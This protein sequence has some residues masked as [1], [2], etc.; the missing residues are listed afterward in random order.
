MLRAAAVPSPAAAAPPHAP[1]RATKLP[2]AAAPVHASPAGPASGVIGQRS[3]RY[4]WPG[5]G[6]GYRTTLSRVPEG[7]GAPS[8]WRTLMAGI[9]CRCTLPSAAACAVME[10][11]ALALRSSLA[12]AVRVALRFA[13]D[14]A[15]AESLLCDRVTGLRRCSA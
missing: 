10:K 9:Q 8:E 14:G 3:A 11:S 13:A 2:R 12:V 1:V 7:G 5:R 15:A 4:P 6:R